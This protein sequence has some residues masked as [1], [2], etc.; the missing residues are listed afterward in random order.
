MHTP[1]SCSAKKAYLGAG[2]QPTEAAQSIIIGPLAGAYHQRGAEHTRARTPA[3]CALTTHTN[4]PSQ[5]LQ[6]QKRHAFHVHMSHPHVCMNVKVYYTHAQH[7]YLYKCVCTCTYT[8]PVS[9]HTC[10]Y[11][12]PHTHT[13]IDYRRPRTRLENVRGHQCLQDA[14]VPTP[15]R[16]QP[17]VERPADRVGQMRPE[18]AAVRRDRPANTWT[19]EKAASSASAAL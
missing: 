2:P 15:S 4:V 9:I 1:K 6:Q 11:T 10:P 5:F 13:C 18:I 7:M 3:C 12:C 8:C 16:A 14:R 19:M 17:S